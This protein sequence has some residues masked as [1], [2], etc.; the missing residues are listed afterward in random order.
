VNPSPETV[1]TL[2]EILDLGANEV[3][4]TSRW[5]KLRVGA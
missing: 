1:A 3:K 5:T 2:Q 4:Y